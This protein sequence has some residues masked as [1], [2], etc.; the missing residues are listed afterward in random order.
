MI[1]SPA[2]GISALPSSPSGQPAVG[3]AEP[4]LTA[5]ARDSRVIPSE[6]RECVR[7]I[8]R[9]RTSVRISRD[10][11]AKRHVEA[12]PLWNMLYI[13][14]MEGSG[15]EGVVAKWYFEE[16][17]RIER[18]VHHCISVARRL[19]NG[20]RWTRDSATA[21]LRERIVANVFARV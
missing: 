16:C 20:S 6:S 9:F 21:K 14:V 10:L 17:P 8:S 18:I 4:L 11:K 19:V 15:A 13:P 12:G 2:R 7:A 3:A 1:A 5:R